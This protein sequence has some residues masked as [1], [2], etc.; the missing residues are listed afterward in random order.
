[1][2][3]PK[4]NIGGLIADIPIL[5]GAMGVGVSGSRLAA[6]V[7]NEGGVGVI[8]GV[9]IGFNEPDFLRN[10]LAANIRALKSQIK[11]AR[12]LAPKGILGVNLMVA[13]NHYGEMVRAAVEEGID[14]IVSGAGLPLKL[15]E[16]VKDIHTRLVP[17]VSSGKAARI[18]AQ[19][20]E[21][22][23]GRTPDMVVVE[24]AE[25]GGHLGFSRQVLETENRPSVMDS[26]KDVV[27]TLHQ[28]SEKLHKKIPVIAAGGIYTGADIARCLQTG[29]DGVQMATRFTATDECDAD[30]RYKQAYLAAQKEDIVIIQSPV[31]MPGRALN[32][33]FIQKLS[34]CGVEIK[35]CSQCLAG[36]NPKVAPYCISAALINAVQGN[37]D[38]GLVFVGS[39]VYRVDQIVSVKN[40]IGELLRDIASAPNA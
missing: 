11:N 34:A 9:N 8:A 30:I 2:K 12:Q 19:Y 39:N 5:Q 16:F 29:A 37:V 13:M 1:M 10:T 36:C 33:K 27:D 14:L 40:L 20:W 21:S 6:A 15:P 26:V 31:G 17:I 38:E 24:G 7:A 23:Y 35:G 18:I 28:F 3:I 4:L 25:A 32:N 22:H